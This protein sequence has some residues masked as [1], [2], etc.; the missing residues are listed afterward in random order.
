ML[1]F[2]DKTLTWYEYGDGHGSGRGLIRRGKD[3]AQLSHKPDL[4]FPFYNLYAEETHAFKVIDD[5]QVPLSEEEIEAVVAWIDTTE[6]GMFQRCL[7]VDEHGR[8]IG[9]CLPSGA[10]KVVRSTPPTE[11]HY[12]YDFDTDAW[13][14]IH[15]VDADGRYVGNVPAGP[16]TLYASSAPPR[17][18]RD[19][20][21]R[22]GVWADETPLETSQAI[23]ILLARDYCDQA[24]ERA[25]AKVT[26]GDTE[27]TFGA[28]KESREN[29][30][31]LC[32]AI[33]NEHAGLLPQGTIPNPRP[34]YPKGATTPFAFPHEGI[35]AIGAAM[36]LVKDT[37][38]A[39]YFAH[40]SAI[41]A[42]STREEV[43]A[44][45]VTTG[46]PG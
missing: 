42:L 10:A 11:D 20:R 13:V 32:T 12:R 34:Y 8:F 9:E 28:D 5:T 18:A 41:K 29:I 7:G 46:W 30:L 24:L 43:E 2:Q 22:N 14:Y 44:Y 6:F 15:A 39:R 33:A 37:Y 40:K 35:L 36:L 45:D 16:D 26:F 23:R 17:T 4:P 1:A 25:V 19:W 38:M 21:W 27:L 31:G 3:T